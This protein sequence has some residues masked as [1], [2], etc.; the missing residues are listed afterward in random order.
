VSLC[1][2]GSTPAIAAGV[3]KTLWKFDDLFSE[4]AA[5]YFKGME[6][7]AR[8]LPR[9]RKLR[10]AWSVGWGI[11]CVLLIVLWA[12]SYSMV[13]IIGGPVS[14]HWYLHFGS[15]DGQFRINRSH[16]SLWTPPKIKR[17]EY[18]RELADTAYANTSRPSGW[19][20]LLRRYYVHVPAWFAVVI[21]ALL[22]AIPWVRWSKRFSLR[23]LLIAT[24]LVAVVLGILALSN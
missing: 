7:E 10:I 4:V 22:A 24:T 14:S 6:G 19:K 12:R 21:V 5:R 11:A 13:E 17:W 9:F 1:V 16:D 3:T 18:Y 20:F 2:A 23:T 8:Q 15:T